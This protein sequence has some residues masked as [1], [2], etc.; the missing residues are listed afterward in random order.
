[1]ASPFFFL[2]RQGRIVKMLSARAVPVR[3]S[4]AF[5]FASPAERFLQELRNYRRSPIAST[6]Q[7]EVNSSFQRHGPGEIRP[8][9]TYGDLLCTAIGS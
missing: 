1:M 4:V 7:R 6:K 2:D 8:T 9:G 5:R 3:P